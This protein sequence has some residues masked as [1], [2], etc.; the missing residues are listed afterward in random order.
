MHA[1]AA[2]K[3]VVM[4]KACLRYGALAMAFD[5]N[6]TIKRTIRA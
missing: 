3:S 1:R 6:F 4:F 2:I 5:V